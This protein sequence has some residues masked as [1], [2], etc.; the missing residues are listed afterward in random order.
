[1]KKAAVC[2]AS[3]GFGAFLILIAGTQHPKFNW[4]Q[5]A[6]M[7]GLMLIFIGAKEMMQIIEEETDEETDRDTDVRPFGLR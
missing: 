1:M 5:V 3:V 7:V 4:I 2:G 6:M